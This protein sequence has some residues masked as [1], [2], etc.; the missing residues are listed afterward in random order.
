M[1]LF[2][3]LAQLCMDV[4]DVAAGC[5]DVADGLPF[6]LT[7]RYR[8]LAGGKRYAVGPGPVFR[9][10]ACQRSRYTGRHK[11]LKNALRD[12]GLPND[13]VDTTLAWLEKVVAHEA[14]TSPGRFGGA[15]AIY[16][17]QPEAAA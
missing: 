6:H 3:Q 8:G 12:A 15:N 14:R 5:A 1:P 4:A 2:S 13:K 10:R 11:R 7:F 9:L 16:L 17:I